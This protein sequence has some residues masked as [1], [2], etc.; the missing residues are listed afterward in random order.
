METKQSV[1][2]WGPNLNRKSSIARPQMVDELLKKS[3][4]SLTLSE[5]HIKTTLRLHFIP[6]RMAKLNNRRWQL[7]SSRMWSKGNTSPLLNANLNSYYGN[8]YGNRFTSRSRDTALEHSP[9]RCS[10][11]PQGH[12]SNH[13]HCGFIN[14]TQKLQTILMSRNREIE[15]ENVVHLRNG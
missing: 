15:R 14:N 3:L 2:N 1:K 10:I 12:L 13:I 8:Q 4:T 5:R 11:V 6:V 9:K 7:M